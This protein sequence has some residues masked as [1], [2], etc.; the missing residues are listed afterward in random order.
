MAATDG[1]GDTGGGFVVSGTRFTVTLGPSTPPGTY[2][3]R[4]IG[5]SPTGQPIGVFSDAATMVVERAARQVS[6]I[7]R[8]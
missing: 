1:F 5:L 4:V 6:Y 8:L 7:G 2:Q 3:I